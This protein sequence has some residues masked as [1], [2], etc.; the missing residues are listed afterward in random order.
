MKNGATDPTTSL[1]RRARWALWLVLALSG[2]TLLLT[3]PDIIATPEDRESS[4]VIGHFYVLPL[5]TAAVAGALFVAA[6]PALRFRNGARRVLVFGLQVSGF[7]CLA[8][9][10]FMAILL[11]QPGT[12]SLGVVSR[13]FIPAFVFYSL[14]AGGS[15]F[16]TYFLTRPRVR[17]LFHSAL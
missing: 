6:I 16:L 9:I 12:V 2:C 3:L 7:L 17:A 11:F 15:F 10:A 1:G 8:V 13:L 4:I 5:V 14:L